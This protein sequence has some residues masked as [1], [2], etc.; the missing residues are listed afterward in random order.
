MHTWSNLWPVLSPASNNNSSHEQ[1]QT[2][3]LTRVQNRALGTTEVE[4]QT[5]QLMATQP[6]PA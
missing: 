6:T 4:H 1:V 2:L 3:P 5:K